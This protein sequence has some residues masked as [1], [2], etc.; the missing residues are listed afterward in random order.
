MLQVWLEKL[1]CTPFHEVGMAYVSL[2]GDEAKRGA[3][4]WVISHQCSKGI[5]AL[6]FPIGKNKKVAVGS[7]L[8]I[9]DLGS[10]ART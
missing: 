2:S 6:V 9:A 3:V 8:H 5:D 1:R 10:V 7:L 4:F